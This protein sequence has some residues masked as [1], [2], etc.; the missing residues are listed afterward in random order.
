MTDLTVIRGEGEHPAD[1][2]YSPILCSDN[3]ALIRGRGEIDASTPA[4]EIR[5]ETR[6]LFSALPG[7]LVEVRSSIRAPWRGKI[8]AIRHAGSTPGRIRTYLTILRPT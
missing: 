4:A 2:I 1:D 3:I 5:L 7:Q 6:Y 8:T